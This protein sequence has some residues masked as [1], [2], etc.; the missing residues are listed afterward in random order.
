[1]INLPLYVYAFYLLFVA[2]NLWGWRG[3][4]GAKCYGADAPEYTNWMPAEDVYP[5]SQ[6]IQFSGRLH[7]GD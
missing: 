1:M 7:I 2:W 3:Y 6:A 4:L 5:G